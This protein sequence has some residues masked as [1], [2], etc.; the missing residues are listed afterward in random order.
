M[1]KKMFKLSKEKDALKEELRKCQAE[2]STLK[3][4]NF[5]QQKEILNKFSEWKSK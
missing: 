2:N 5:R 3:D 1:K 4:L